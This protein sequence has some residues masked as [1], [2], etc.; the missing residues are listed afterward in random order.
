[1]TT[2]TTAKKT[3]ATSSTKSG[4]SADERAA[5][6]ER[7]KELRAEAKGAKDREK[8]LADLESKIADMPDGDQ[9]L[10]KAIHRIVTETAPDLMPKTWYGMPAYADADGKVVC[11]FKA[12]S[13]FDVRYG[14]LGFNEEATLD[15]GT[16]W[17]TVFAITAINAANEKLIAKLVK[18][19]VG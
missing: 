18:K 11:F 4:F 19:A 12:A 13:K 16:M 15:E 17:P 7:A 9:T 10:A 2:K 1:M 14:E 3:T 8:G 5:M 6:K